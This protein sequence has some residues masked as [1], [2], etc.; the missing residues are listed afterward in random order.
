[1]GPTG[2]I[3][4][5]CDLMCVCVYAYERIETERERERENSVDGKCFMYTGM[6]DIFDD[7][8]KQ[9]ALPKPRLLPRLWLIYCPLKM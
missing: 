6:K 2:E 7:F 5:V 3:L 1:M 8:P 4:N 9:L